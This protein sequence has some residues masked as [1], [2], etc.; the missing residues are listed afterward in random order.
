MDELRVATTGDGRL[1]REQ[2]DPA[3]SRGENRGVRLRGKHADDRNRELPL[4]V[5]KRCGRRGVAR[6]DDELDALLLEV[7][8]DLGREAAD[9]VERTRTVGEPRAVSEVHEVLVRQRDEALVQDGESAHARV[10]HADGAGIHRRG[11]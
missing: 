8:G 6:G 3:V 2:A 5:R 7:A 4:K 1:G 9:L 10:E 11:V